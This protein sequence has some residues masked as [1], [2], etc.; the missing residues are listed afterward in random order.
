MESIVI[1]SRI[2]VCGHESG[3]SGVE[4]VSG[5]GITLHFVF[6]VFFRVKAGLDPSLKGTFVVLS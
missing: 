4:D 1:T 3:N 5:I 2:G 6:S